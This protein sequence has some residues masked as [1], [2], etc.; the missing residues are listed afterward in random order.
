M[1]HGDQMV[2][3]Y[4]IIVQ[5]ARSGLE[6]QRE[7]G[8]F[9]P[10]ENY[11]YNEPVT[12]VRQT[13]IWIRILTK[14]YEITD[15]QEFADAAH[16]G[17]DYLL[18]HEAR[19]YGYTFHCRHVEDKCNGLV[20]QARAIEALIEA[21]EKLNR[22]DAKDTARHVFSLHP[23]D[24][25]I[26][27]WNSIEINGSNRKFDR[28]LNHQITFAAV[29]SVFIDESKKVES[30]IQS[31]LNNLKSNIRINSDGRV[32][33]YV[34]PPIIKIILAMTKSLQNHKLLLSKVRNQIPNSKKRKKE[35]GYMPV[36]LS[37]L[38]DIK[39]HFPAHSFWES[40]HYYAMH[41]YL[42]KNIEQLISKNASR[43]GPRLSKISIAGVYNKERDIKG[44]DPYE[45]VSSENKIFNGLE[46]KNSQ[47]M[48][49][50]V[51]L[52]ELQNYR[53]D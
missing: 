48:S 43:Y 28:T 52:L 2:T 39:M 34:D 42:Q 4:D 16:R 14:A 35:L 15:H 44:P 8:S 17:V 49:A 45:L 6:Y 47:Q 53:I 25:N 27:L 18:S 29:G 12:P 40:H 1:R 31:F 30:Y 33:H 22:N 19:P 3:I 46:L 5:N 9:P 13:S 36:V 50:V 41:E 37:S 24:E 26:G 21:G 11:P 23:F 7:D 32:H 10:G 51:V 38:T 20:G